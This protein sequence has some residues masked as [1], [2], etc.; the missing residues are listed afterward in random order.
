MPALNVDLM[1]MR[2][3]CLGRCGI[4]RDR[5]GDQRKLQGP[6][7][8]GTRRH[9]STPVKRNFNGPRN[10]QFHGSSEV[11]MIR[12]LLAKYRAKR[13]FSKTSEP[14]GDTK[15]KK[16]TGLRFVIQKHAAS[17]LHYD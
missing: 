9:F 17:H 2:F 6:L 15:V 7:P 8:V 13:D 12:K 5:T 16:A 10:F 1:E 3:L 4:K 11:P 14:S